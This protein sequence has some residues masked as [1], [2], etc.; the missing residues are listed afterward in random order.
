M[1]NDFETPVNDANLLGLRD[2]PV[3]PDE[4]WHTVEFPYGPRH[5]D[6]SGNPISFKDWLRLR[7]FAGPDYI[8]V[9]YSEVGSYEISTVWLG[10]DLGYGPEHKLIFETMVFGPGQEIDVQR[11]ADYDAALAGHQRTVEQVRLILAADLP[12]EE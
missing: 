1:N 2:L 5:W 6:R 7:Q 10:L 3:G 4:F 9:G 8:R 12:K 11:Y